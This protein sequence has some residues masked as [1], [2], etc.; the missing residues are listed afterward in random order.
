MENATTLETVPTA[1]VEPEEAVD[2][3]VALAVYNE[4]GHIEA[5]LER[6]RAALDASDYRYEIIVVDDA[7]TD[8]SADEL[9]RIPDIRLIRLAKNRGSGFARR[10]AT[11]AARGR[12]VVWSD[13]DMT[14]PNDLIP[15]LVGRLD[16]GY[17]QVVGART[18]EEGTHKFFR[19]PAK[20]LIRRLASFLVDEPIPDLNS[21]L[22]AF[23]RDV[24]TQFL[25]MLPAGFSCV[26]TLTMCFLANGY[27]V[28][29]MP[30]A[31]AERAGRSKFHW[32]RDTKRYLTQVIRMVLTFNPLRVFMPLGF[33]LLLVGGAKLGYDIVTKDFRVGTNTLLIFFAA[34]QVFAIG[35]LADLVVRLSRPRDQVDPA[36]RS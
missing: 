32:Y 36:R 35:L 17:D 14:Y 23:R 33:L 3:T 6:I 24:G 19:V 2:V 34:F 8:N 30:I 27:S 20:W 11:S 1:D 25:H 4:A 5:E 9:A 16:S 7:S 28:G 22:R 29:Y 31:Y 21:G 15:Q 18:T 10:T 12:V 13:V 26:T